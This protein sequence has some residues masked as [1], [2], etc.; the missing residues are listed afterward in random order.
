MTI[1]VR[2]FIMTSDDTLYRVVGTKFTAMIN[3]PENHPLLRFAGQRVRMAEAIVELDNRAPSGIYRLLFGMLRF[4]DH[5][6]LDIK[7]L[8]R[9]NFALFEAFNEQ[10][11]TSGTVV[12]A[13]SRFVAQ[14]GRWKPTPAVEYRIRQA[15]LGKA[16][17]KRLNVEA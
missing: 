8:M 9:Q 10:Q 17:C 16:A 3:D 13:E 15:A 12:D 14:G 1:S 4:D 7:T 2:I 6:M 11:A 5:G